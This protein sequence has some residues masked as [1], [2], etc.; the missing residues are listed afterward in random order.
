MVAPASGQYLSLY[1]DAG[2]DPWAAFNR[3][4][5]LQ[6]AQPPAT[7]SIPDPTSAIANGLGGASAYAPQMGPTMQDAGGDPWGVYRA[8]TRPST[9]QTVGPDGSAGHAPVVTVGQD[10][11]NRGAGQISPVGQPP[12]N[13]N[14][15]GYKTG[16]WNLG[17]NAYTYTIPQGFA[18]NQ[19]LYQHG[20]DP[21]QD[22]NRIAFA[23]GDGQQTNF[24]RVYGWMNELA[25]VNG[26]ADIAQAPP[27]FQQWAMGAAVGRLRTDYQNSGANWAQSG[28]SGY[29]KYLAGGGQPGGVSAPAPAMTPQQINPDGTASHGGAPMVL[30]PMGSG[31]ATGAK[32]AAPP[33]QLGHTAQTA[34]GQPAMGGQGYRIGQGQF[35]DINA[36]IAAARE[37]PDRAAKVRRLAMGQRGPT[38]SIIGKYMDNMYGRA[39]QAALATAGFNGNGGGNANPLLG[40]LEGAL[41]STMGGGAEFVPYMT[42]LASNVV[43]GDF[44]GMPDQ[45]IQAA[46]AAAN[47]LGS[48]G[49]GDVG[50]SRLNADYSNLMDQM[51]EEALLRPDTTSGGILPRILKGSAFEQAMRRFAATR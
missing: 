31:M 32:G 49:L 35:E 20:Y 4:Q 48:L 6:R 16:N 5:Q 27:E 51:D 24:D 12:G 44:T 43:G 9:P 36:I 47:A 28:F 19:N 3:F 21:S 22:T 25:R 45:K 38:L 18:A 26:I 40:V 8:N 42:G 46:L 1:G 37:D 13:P 17:R 10:A 50:A 30:P 7:P 41:G 39:I 29:D 2:R 34:S 11:R 33:G 23:G 14:P 15:N